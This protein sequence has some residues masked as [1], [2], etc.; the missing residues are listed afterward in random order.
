[1]QSAEP[2]SGSRA[3]EI[4][5]CAYTPESA[6]VL[7]GGW[8]GH[9]RLWEA[10]TGRQVSAIP[11]SGKALSACAVS[12][13]GRQWLSGSM[14]GLMS[15]WDP[16]SHQTRIQFVAHTRP[17]ASI[18]FS[19]D[20]QMVATA[21][22]D[23]KLSLRST[24]KIRDGQVLSGHGDIV[25]GCR[26]LPDGN[27][28]LS[29]S[30]DGTVLIWDVPTAQKAKAL[31]GHSDRVTCAAASPDGQWVASASRD[32]TL[33]LWDWQDQKVATSADT[34]NEVRG[35]FFLPEGQSLLAV[36]DEGWVTVYTYPTLEV[37][38]EFDTGAKVQYAEL[39]PSGTQFAL[40]CEDGKV[41]FVNVDGVARAPIPV[42]ATETVRQEAS[43]LGRL[44]GVFRQ[45]HAYSCTC[46]A[47]QQP[48]E[49]QDRLPGGPA[50]CPHC[51][52]ALRF[53]TLR[54]PT[55]STS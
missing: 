10:S 26:F 6:F 24:A 27:H 21:S 23:K 50:P 14:E 11:A 44:F 48:F 25:G 53:H 17:I 40:G 46:P 22:W 15:V 2:T 16:V 30:H 28:L 31:K 39:A 33:K 13:D 55:P 1:M 38:D 12:P 47:C 4:F 36:D 7:S 29:W 51:R 35:L 43:G 41:R 54:Q 34:E 19:P 45:V 49:L 18:V 42:T 52:Q 3:G 37:H 5:A 20:G 32:N 9:L 8:D